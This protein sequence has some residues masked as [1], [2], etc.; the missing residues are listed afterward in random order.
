LNTYDFGDNIF[1]AVKAPRIHH[2]LLP[3]EI[4]VEDGYNETITHDLSKLGHKVDDY[5]N[6]CTVIFHPLTLIHVR[7]PT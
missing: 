2:Q 3:N 4:G 6:K 7:L 1:E 5:K